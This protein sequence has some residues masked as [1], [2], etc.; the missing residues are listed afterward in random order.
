MIRFPANYSTNDE[1]RI[2]DMRT[3]EQREAQRQRDME[4]DAAYLAADYES[5]LEAQER[6]EIARLDRLEDERAERYMEGSQ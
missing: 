2:L 1:G 5:Y 4:E 3:P 6:E